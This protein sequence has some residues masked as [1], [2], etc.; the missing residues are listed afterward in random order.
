MTLTIRFELKVALTPSFVNWRRLRGCWNGSL[1]NET[2][3]VAQCAAGTAPREAGAEV[4]WRREG[5]TRSVAPLLS[6]GVE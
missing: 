1:R 2:R 3:S 4:S 5:T 6:A